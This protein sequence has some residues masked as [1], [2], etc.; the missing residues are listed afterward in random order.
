MSECVS[1]LLFGFMVCVCVQKKLKDRLKSGGI[2]NRTEE[3]KEQISRNKRNVR[4][5]VV[6]EAQ[7]GAWR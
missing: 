7:G 6:F 3:K 1:V 5:V 2:T 4:L